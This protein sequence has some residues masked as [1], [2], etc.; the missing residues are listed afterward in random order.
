MS[1]IQCTLHV[2]SVSWNL[3][4]KNTIDIVKVV[5]VGAFKTKYKPNQLWPSVFEEESPQ[6]LGPHFASGITISVQV[7][8]GSRLW[9]RCPLA[10][11]MCTL[12][13]VA[14]RLRFRCQANSHGLG[15]TA[16]CPSASRGLAVH[17]CS[18][19]KLTRLF[20]IIS[21]KPGDLGPSNFCM[22]SKLSGSITRTT[23][24]S[25]WMGPQVIR[26]HMRSIAC[27]M[28]NETCCL[29]GPRQKP[30][31]NDPP[32]YIHVRGICMQW[33]QHQIVFSWNHLH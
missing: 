10:K 31:H 2:V 8:F 25:K 3:H 27:A 26:H 7:H 13:F 30:F 4:W 32:Q 33:T 28:V 17:L 21:F 5:A 29:W 18:Q 12:A 22:N 9:R 1:A 20:K 14:K 16:T 19:Q 15:G 6:N 23:F 24:D 11:L